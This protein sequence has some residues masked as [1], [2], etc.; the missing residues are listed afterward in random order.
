MVFDGVPRTVPQAEELDT[1]LRAHARAL[2]AAILIDVPDEDVVRR[3][4]GRHQG[5]TDD[6]PGTAR[7]RLRVYHRETE[8]LIRHYE[9]R[10]LLRRVDGAQDPDSVENGIRAVLG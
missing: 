5:R 8:P 2:T 1:L 6:T 3:I 4:A 10:G 7:E 9:A